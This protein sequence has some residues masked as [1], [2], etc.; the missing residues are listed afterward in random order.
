VSATK[1]TTNTKKSFVLFVSFV[2]LTFVS[3]SPDASAQDRFEAAAQFPIVRSDAFDTTETGV[4]GRLA[5][6][7]SSALGADAEFNFYPKDLGGAVPFS[8][9]RVEGLFGVTLGPRLGG[10]RPFVRLRPGFVT[11]RGAGPIVC[12]LIFPPPLSCQ[13]AAGRT[14]F[15]LD[16]GG[17]VDLSVGDKG[18]VRVDGGDRMI[19]YPGPSLLNGEARQESFYGHDVRFSLGAGVRF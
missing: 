12:I 1:I 19:K 3:L 14:M 2:A 4:G 9:S 10:V 8:R 13:L 7:P 18:V 16:I 5:W 17:G 15:A 6:Y 11:F